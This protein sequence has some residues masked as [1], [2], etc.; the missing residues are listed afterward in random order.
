[1]RAFVETAQVGRAAA[2]AGIDRSLP[3]QRGWRDDPA[4]VAAL[5]RAREMSAVVFEDE[6]ARRAIEVVELPR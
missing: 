6:A 1:M 5:K 2:L 3:Y 4:F